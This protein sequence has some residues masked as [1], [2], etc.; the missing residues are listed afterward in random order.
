MAKGLSI[1]SK[2]I[3]ILLSQIEYGLKL[4]VSG[5]RWDLSKKGMVIGYV[6]KWVRGNGSVFYYMI[7]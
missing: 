3:M 4:L 5:I 1:C 2:I 7:P 6:R